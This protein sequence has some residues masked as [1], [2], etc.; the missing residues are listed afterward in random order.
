MLFIKLPLCLSYYNLIG[1]LD[2]LALLNFFKLQLS[3]HFF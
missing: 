1:G 3:V 2:T